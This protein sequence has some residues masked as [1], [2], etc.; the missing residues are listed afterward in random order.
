MALATVALSFLSLSSLTAGG[1]KAAAEVLKFLIHFLG[2]MHQPLHLCGP[3]HGGN[4]YKVLVTILSPTPNFPPF[5]THLFR[6][7][8]H[9]FPTRSLM[10]H[11]DRHQIT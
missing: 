3:N 8:G 5:S 9:S 10:R 4:D 7:L 11:S 2:D 6:A 1:P